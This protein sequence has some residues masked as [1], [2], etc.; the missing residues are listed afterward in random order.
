MSFRDLTMTNI[1]E[2]LRRWQA[3]HSARAIAR[4]RVVDRKTA[5][6]YIE[7]A[8]EEGL[9]KAAELTDEVVGRIA[10]RVQMREAPP[11]SDSRKALDEHRQQIA[12]WLK[13]PEPLR[14]TRV[15]ELLVREGVTTS[16][17][18][19][20]RYAS[21]ELGW[22][23]PKSTILIDDPPPGEEAQI[24][25]GEMGYVTTHDGK[26][27]KLW[28]LIVT[29]SMSRYQFVWPSF[30]QTVEALVEGLDAAWQ[31]FGGVTQR[32]VPDN[33][34]AAVVKARPQDPQINESFAEY[35]QSRRFFVDPARV[36][37]PQDKP[38]VENQVAYVRERWFAGEVFDDDLKRLREH[39]TRWCREVAG[40]RIHGTTRRVPY[41]VFQQEEIAHMLPAP[42]DRYDV[43]IWADAKVHPDHHIQVA[44]SLYSVP[45][46]YLHQQ[47]RVRLD[48][49]TVRIYFRNELIKAHQRVAPGKR[50]TDTNDYPPGKA[51]Y[52]RR[53][54]EG[55]IAQAKQRG[56]AIG[57]FAEQL[58]GGPLPWVRM[59]Q[60]YG[61]LRLCD[62][63]GTDRVE[64]VC[65]RSLAFDVVDV[66]RIEAMLKRAY[67]SEK[68]AEPGRVIVLPSS[69]FARS[70]ESFATIVTKAGEP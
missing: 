61:L 23:E 70:S 46:K 29:L 24:D 60:G 1:R 4:D 42:Q 52:A 47:V 6:R 3:G 69:R 53:S 56:T 32:I 51:P 33:L 50:S 66:P 22:H 30:H 57:A 59:R 9:E 54:V 5:S 12:D 39:A 65:A 49:K 41:D 43:P 26:R 62:K 13:G 28:V 58:L 21:D 7:A 8:A 38:R 64:V 14:L 16:Y 37:K 25:Y 2:V 31:F 20:R 36:R 18:T 15:Q 35:A 45:T 44:K 11:R 48:S 19:L 27:R 10:A 34:T 68:D 63:Y 67:Q 55:I 17:T 40:T